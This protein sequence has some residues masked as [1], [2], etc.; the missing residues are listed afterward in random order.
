MTTRS[1]DAVLNLFWF[2]V[3]FRGADQS[4]PLLLCR[5]D[6]L[7]RRHMCQDLA[8]DARRVRKDARP[9]VSSY[10]PLSDDQAHKLTPDDAGGE[11]TD[12]STRQ[13]KV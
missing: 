13:R 4:Q 6:N 1:F 11:V 10:N 12:S 2:C 3:R 9:P 5:L 7:F 8:A